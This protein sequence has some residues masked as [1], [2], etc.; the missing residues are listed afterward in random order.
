ME[1]V[2]IPCHVPAFE[3]D[4]FSLAEIL[5]V[6]A[7]FNID[8]KIEVTPIMDENTLTIH[9]FARRGSDTIAN[10]RIKFFLKLGTTQ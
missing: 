2:V 7:D 4:S 1:A 5:D 6:F 8:D 3:P 10:A 9:F